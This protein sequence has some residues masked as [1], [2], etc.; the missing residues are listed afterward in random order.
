MKQNTSNKKIIIK[1][2]DIAFFAVLL[3]IFGYFFSRLVYCQS[4]YAETGNTEGY[5]SDILAYMQ[6]IQGP[7]AEITFEKEVYSTLDTYPLFFLLGKV[8]YKFM[9]INHAI[10]WAE[11]I[12]NSLAII[13]S[14]YFFEKSLSLK[15]DENDNVIRHILISLGVCACFIM[16]MWWLPRFGKI[17]LPFKDQ[18]F[19]GTYS[20]N[21]WHNATYIA[22]RP[23][24]VSTFFAFVYLMKKIPLKK[25][26]AAEDLTKITVIDYILFSVSL[27]LSV[28]A[29]PTFALVFF[30]ASAIVF[31][32]RLIIGKGK[33]IK[34]LVFVALAYIPTCAVLLYQFGGVFGNRVETTE[35]H[36]IGLTFFGVWKSANPHVAAAIFYANV[37]SLA[38]LVFFFKEIKS[39]FLYRFGVLFFATALIEA[40]F[41]CEKGFR[42]SH[43]NFSWGYMHGIFFFAMVSIAVLLK[44]CFKKKKRWPAIIVPT[45]CLLSQVIFGILYFKGLYYGLD[46]NTLLPSHWL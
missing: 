30:S 39:D 24:A 46:Y 10:M 40:G 7:Q 1:I 12:C 42:Y 26:E 21:P 6:H 27:L 34:N 25:G 37:F 8:L 44:E 2:A 23:F 22:V 9:D 45:I 31:L 11:L 20:G 41:L 43:F 36:G 18:V 5:Y 14:K 3:F 15:D 4:L 13:L 19:Y 38:T 33:T 28:L 16:S 32:A 29:K 35:E 17:T